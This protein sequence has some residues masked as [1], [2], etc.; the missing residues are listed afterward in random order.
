LS[1]SVISAAF[2]ES[3]VCISEAGGP[4]R[5]FDVRTGVEAWRFTPAKGTHLIRVAFC[6][7]LDSFV[8]VSWPYEKGGEVFLQRFSP[9]DGS[10]QVI[11]EAGSWTQSEFYSRGSRLVTATGAVFDVASGNRVGVL[12]LPPVESPGEL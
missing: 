6:D 10:P 11:V 7:A 4:V 12:P 5:A 2:S 1:F 9:A 3:L 8:G